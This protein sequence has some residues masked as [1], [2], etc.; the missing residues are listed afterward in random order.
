MEYLNLIPLAMLAVFVFKAFKKAKE[1]EHS[2]AYF[3]DT[4]VKLD[5]KCKNFFGVPLKDF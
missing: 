3:T 2:D 4:K 5:R 1:P